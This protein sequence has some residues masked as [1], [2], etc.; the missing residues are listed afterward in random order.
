MTKQNSA[1]KERTM[2]NILERVVI[3]VIALIAIALLSGCAITK[4]HVA[5]SYVPQANVSSISGAKDVKVKV[6]VPDE[7]TMKDKV[8]AKKNGF[9]SEMAPILANNDVAE[10]LQGAIETELKQRGFAISDGSMHVV[11]KLS[12]FYCDFKTGFWSG[13]A[14]AEVTMNVQVNRP[15]GSIAYSKMVAG[16]GTITHIQI[17]SEGNAQM[18]LNA[19]LQDSVAKLFADPAFVDVLLKSGAPAGLT[20]SQAK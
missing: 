14:V 19:A 10:V 15:D 16:E 12:K 1:G 5:V 11:A 4:G 6:E 8:G 7:R 3:S 2:K 17:Y 9:G 18:A 13:N 20:A